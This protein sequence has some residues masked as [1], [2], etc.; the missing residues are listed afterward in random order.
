MRCH[1]PVTDTWV[2]IAI[3]TA[4]GG[5]YFDDVMFDKTS[6]FEA[7]IM[8]YINSIQPRFNFT[9]AD[10]KKSL[11]IADIYAKIAKSEYTILSDY[12]TT[13]CQLTLQNGFTVI[14]KSACV[15]VRTFNKADGEKYAFEDAVSKV[16]ELEGYLLKERQYDQV[17]KAAQT[18]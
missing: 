5:R 13:I 10:Q 6:P 14:G 1:D 2:E 15:D 16:W 9:Q 4:I 3:G 7:A 17:E 8:W 12:R 11:T 18:T